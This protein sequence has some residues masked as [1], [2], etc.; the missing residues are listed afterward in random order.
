MRLFLQHLR[1]E[2]VLMGLFA[3]A[4]DFESGMVLELEWV[5]DCSSMILEIWSTVL[6]MVGNIHN[7]GMG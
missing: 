5:R 2:Q 4:L 7:P 6:M 1:F 3:A